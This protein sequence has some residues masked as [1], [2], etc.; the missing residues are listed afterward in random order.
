MHTDVTHASVC[1][2]LRY[3]GCVTKELTFR[4]KSGELVEGGENPACTQKEEDDKQ[5]SQEDA[6][7]VGSQTRDCSGELSAAAHRQRVGGARRLSGEGIKRSQPAGGTPSLLLSLL[8]PKPRTRAL[9]LSSTAPRVPPPSAARRADTTCSS[10]GARAARVALECR[11]V[12]YYT[13]WGEMCIEREGER[14]KGRR[15]N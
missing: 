12:R 5:Q 3:P 9:S 14:E 6:R 8:R 1:T 7:C 15:A 2:V 10:T 4:G 13:S 11:E